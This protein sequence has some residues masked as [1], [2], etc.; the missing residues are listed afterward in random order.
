MYNFGCF[1]QDWHIIISFLHLVEWIPTTTTNMLR[2]KHDNK[3]L[4]GEEEKERLPVASEKRFEVRSDF[5][6]FHA[7]NQPTIHLSIYVSIVHALIIRQSKKLHRQSECDQ[8]IMY[9][10]TDPHTH[11]HTYLMEYLVFSTHRTQHFYP[12]SMYTHVG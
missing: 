6:F 3:K 2:K 5:V 12:H 10:H 7:T 1:L 4:V 11:G 8:D 9:M